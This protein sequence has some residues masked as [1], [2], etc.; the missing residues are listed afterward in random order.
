MSCPERASASS[1]VTKAAPERCVARMPRRRLSASA[2]TQLPPSRRTISPLRARSCR[3]SRMSRLS[4]REKAPMRRMS[5][6]RR[7]RPAFSRMSNKSCSSKSSCFFMIFPEAFQ[8]CRNDAP[9][10]GAFSRGVCAARRSTRFQNP[11][12]ARRSRRSA[13]RRSGRRRTGPRLPAKSRER[14]APA[15]AV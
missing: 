4:L 7:G 14:K 1:G 15:D 10:K 12:R 8:E 5:S 11:A 9:Q 2:M 6:R 3:A 13:R